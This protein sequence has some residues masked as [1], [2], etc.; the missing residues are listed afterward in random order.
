MVRPS[1][2]IKD[3]A[4]FIIMISHVI[5][6]RKKR[7]WAI[8]MSKEKVHVRE[9]TVRLNETYILS[10]IKFKNLWRAMDRK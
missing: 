1:G 9:L 6:V 8:I 4:I 5:I 7:T 3:T 2:E 10:L